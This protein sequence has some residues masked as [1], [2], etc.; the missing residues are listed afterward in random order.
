MDVLHSS[1]LLAL[2]LLISSTENFPAIHSIHHPVSSLPICSYLNG[3]TPM[4]PSTHELQ[5]STQCT[6]LSVII[7]TV[8]C[9]QVQRRQH[10]V[11]FF[12]TL[13]LLL[14]FHLQQHKIINNKISHLNYFLQLKK[15][16]RRRKHELPAKCLPLCCVE[17]RK[18]SDNI[19]VGHK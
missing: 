5:T 14:G 18:G 8:F 2:L 11:H 10:F 4:S 15:G 19:S 1:H 13:F 6:I 12:E 9:S 16:G 3:T 17:L 7:T